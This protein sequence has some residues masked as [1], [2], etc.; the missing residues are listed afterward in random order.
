LKWQDYEETAAWADNACGV[1]Q[2]TGLK[3][4][5][6]SG[7]WKSISDFKISI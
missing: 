7:K 6:E 5:T 1:L 4:K 2:A 3:A